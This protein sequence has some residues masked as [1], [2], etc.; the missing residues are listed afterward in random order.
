MEER[1]G[2]IRDKLD[3]KILILFILHRLP[4]PVTFEELSDLTLCDEG[5]SY[6]DFT[7][8]VS[9]LVST[10]HIST[11]GHT[12]TLTE[13]GI[14]N[15]EITEDSIP[16]SV[17]MKA[18]RNAAAV[19]LQMNRKSMIS[20]SHE[21]RRKG[22]YT[23]ELSLSDGISEVISMKLYAASEAQAEAL[24]EGFASN[25]ENIYNGI[26]KLILGPV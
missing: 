6:F 4:E 19:R 10:G 3:I 18:E 25:A 15:G 23:V 20:T 13:K 12:Y 22:G 9:E 7:E 21:I 24:K 26:L 16:F 5:I 1:L 14:R 2:F 8:C 17:R 11:D